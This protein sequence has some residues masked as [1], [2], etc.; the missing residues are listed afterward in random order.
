[1]RFL[2]DFA[3]T[4]RV[5]TIGETARDRGGSGRLGCLHLFT[6]DDAANPIPIRVHQ[7]RAIRAYAAPR[8]SRI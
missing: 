1:L 5:R 3:P 2:T 8:S 6:C 4:L 7:R